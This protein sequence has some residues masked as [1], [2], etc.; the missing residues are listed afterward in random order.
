M[1]VARRIEERFIALAQPLMRLHPKI[2]RATDGRIGRRLPGLPP[3]LVLDHVGA[4]SGIQ[5][6]SVVGYVLDGDDVLVV[7]SQGGSPTNPAWFHNLKANPDVR[8]QIGGEVRD[9]HARVASASER[10]Q[11]WPKATAA[12]PGFQRYQDHTERVIPVVVLERRGDAPA[13]A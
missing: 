8:I 4:K 6:S 13:A 12:Y 10:A 2:Y 1:S 11:L 5:R 3:L 9:V 7:A